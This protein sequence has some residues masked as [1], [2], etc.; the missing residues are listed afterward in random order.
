MKFFISQTL[1]N[2][3]RE[4]SEI[5]TIMII[6][7]ACIALFS[8]LIYPHKRFSYTVVM[9]GSCIMGL[10]IPGVEQ[11]PLGT[12]LSQALQNFDL[13]SLCIGLLFFVA[14]LIKF[15]AISA[16]DKE[17]ELEEH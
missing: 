16:A 10:S 15:C 3:F 13:L 9:L 1:T 17:K 2:L 5:I 12:N 7:S 11:H 14:G 8:K 6:I 4:H